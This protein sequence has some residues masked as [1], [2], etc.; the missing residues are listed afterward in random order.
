M[1]PEQVGDLLSLAAAYDDR[2]VGESQVIAWLA[3]IGDLDFAEAQPAVISHYQESP[4]K[5]MPADVR[6]RVKRDR[7]ATEDQNQLRKLLD[8]A[9]YKA[10][11]AQADE[12]FLRKLAART[13]KPAAPKAIES[14]LA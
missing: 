7:R 1:T 12:R 9:A 3:A 8:P 4:R 6:Q 11:I 10:E 5:I 14:G 2:E 13:G